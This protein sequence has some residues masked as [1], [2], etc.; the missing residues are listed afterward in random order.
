M[1]GG[2]AFGA[3]LAAALVDP[4]FFGSGLEAG[5]LAVLATGLA[6]GFFATGFALGEAFFAT[7]LDFVVDFTVGL[8]ALAFFDDPVEEGFFV[9]AT[10]F[11][12]LRAAAEPFTGV[13]FAAGF[14][15]E[16]FTA[17]LD[18]ALLVAGFLA[19]GFCGVFLAGAFL[20]LVLALLTRLRSFFVPVDPCDGSF[21]MG[22]MRKKCKAVA[23]RPF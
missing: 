15:A 13:F 8:L 12:G 17:G 18:P 7:G 1:A 4:A 20:E 14:L 3:G 2:L 22:A 6:A 5:F 10:G 19:T 16:A 21:N 23:N 11:A 9:F